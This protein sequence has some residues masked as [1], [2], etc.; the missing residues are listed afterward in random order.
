MHHTGLVGG[1]RKRA[2][3]EFGPERVPHLGIHCGYRA[4]NCV[5]LEVDAIRAG[6]G[7]VRRM[8]YVAEWPDGYGVAVTSDS[9]TALC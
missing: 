1:F 2:E 9:R 6:R 4:E 8:N 7:S 5:A 3:H